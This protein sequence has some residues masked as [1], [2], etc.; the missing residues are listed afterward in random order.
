MFRMLVFKYEPEETE[1]YV[2]PLRTGC[3]ISTAI[4]LS[5]K[6]QQVTNV[7]FK[8]HVNMKLI[9]SSQAKKMEEE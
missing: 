4:S 5:C 1:V 7:N 2:D 8:P 6:P 9:L 3:D